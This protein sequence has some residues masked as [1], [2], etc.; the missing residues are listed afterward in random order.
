LL[1]NPGLL[2]PRS[3]E[4]TWQKIQS[5]RTN[6]IFLSSRPSPLTITGTRTRCCGVIA[7][8]P[9]GFHG[10]ASPLFQRHCEA[11]YAEVIFTLLKNA[12]GK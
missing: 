5:E 6:L 8:I 4:A 11:V 1:E 9:V 7:V 10:E 2:S 12:T 3:R